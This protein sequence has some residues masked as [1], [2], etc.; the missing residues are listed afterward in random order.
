MIEV[1]IR[2]HKTMSKRSALLEDTMLS[3]D[4]PNGKTLTAD[5]PSRVKPGKKGKLRAFLPMIFILVAGVIGFLIPT[6]QKT[7]EAGQASLSSANNEQASQPIQVYDRQNEEPEPTVSF[8]D[9][10]YVIVNSNDVGFLNVRSEAST[11][12]T[13][14]GQLEIGDKLKVIS[15]TTGWVQVELEEEMS[16]ETEG[17]VSSEYVEVVIEKEAIN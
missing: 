11:A 5:L 2:V 16:G 17:W 8:V 1:D 15:Q 14:L 6:L 3:E 10:K 12:S 13:K 7:D 4:N 9:V